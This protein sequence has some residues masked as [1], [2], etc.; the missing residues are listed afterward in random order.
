[1]KERVFLRRRAVT[2]LL[3]LTNVG[4]VTGQNWA[5]TGAPVTNWTAVACSADAA[6]IVGVTYYGVAFVSTNGGKN[7]TASATPSGSLFS[8]ASS[9]DGVRLVACG[10]WVI[11]ST[12]GGLTWSGSSLSGSQFTS[13]ASSAD[14]SRLLVTGSLW[15]TAGSV[16]LSTNSG[17]SWTTF[18]S[19]VPLLSAACSADGSR[20]V[21]VG[22][23]EYY[24]GYYYSSTARSVDF[25]GSFSFATA[26]NGPG[27]AVVSSAD[28][29]RTIA[30][31]PR[32]SFFTSSNSGATW[33]DT[34]M[35]SGNSCAL[36]CSAD[37]KIVFSS[38]GPNGSDPGAI[39]VSADGG[40]SWTSAN[41]P[42]TNW[43]GVACSADGTTAFAV[44]DGGGIYSSQSA[45]RPV[46]AVTASPGGALISWV[47]PARPFVLQ[48]SSEP[49][50]ANWTDI[51][52]P[53]TLN[54][55]NLEYQ[56]TIP[57][58]NRAGFFR[59]AQTAP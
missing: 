35:F 57:V 11:T 2:C 33:S 15:P 42:A 44:V 3:L 47:I 48:Q 26:T 13:V 52:N 58:T 49:I 6:H 25:G 56:L 32:R 53:P 16:Y 45:T 41:A 14:G 1:M 10:A 5:L 51:E 29:L 30:A 31:A 12:D 36:A 37:G 59:L 38:R 43:A 19:S 27:E 40:D 39:Y 55:T 9:P 28:G 18:G 7:W 54:S 8:V 20:L 21:V 17:N 4:V 34:G 24:P 46:L 50:S 22:Y 23:L